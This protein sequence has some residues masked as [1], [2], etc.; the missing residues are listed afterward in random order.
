MKVTLKLT[1][2]GLL[3]ALRW[4]HIDF[5]DGKLNSKIAR[6]LGP[7]IPDEPDAL[8]ERGAPYGK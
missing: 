5:L 7:E 8:D 3:E 4:R 1:Y 2:D 6:D